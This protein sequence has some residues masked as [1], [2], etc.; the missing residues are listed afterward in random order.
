MNFRRWLD[1]ALLLTC[2]VTVLLTLQGC[3]NQYEEATRE[4]YGTTQQRLLELGKK[5]EVGQVSNALLIKTYARQLSQ[6]QPALDE[7]AQVLGRD[8]TTEGPQYQGL[9]ERLKKID[10][11]PDNKGQFVPVFQELEALHAATDP[12]VYNDALLDVV[13]TLADLSGGTLARINIPK[14]AQTA[15]IEGGGTVPGSYLVGNPNYGHWNQDS[16]GNS[17]WSWYGKYALFSSVIRGFGGFGSNYHSGPIYHD[18]WYKRDRYGYYHD[19]GR[20][21]YGTG[22]DRHSWDRGQ[23]R[24]EKKGIK[25]PKPKNYGSVSGQ[26]RVSTYA[27]MRQKSAS[28]LRS[29]SIPSTSGKTAK[30]SSSF[31]GSSTRGTS[32]GSRSGFGGK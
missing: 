8:A 18:S 10:Q 14:D 30:R 15:D 3:S 5:I 29:G 9:L 4:A 22:T 24:L 1:H 26:K 19:Y 17:F 11:Q 20:K 21:T 25:T 13:N 28:T 16:S 23:K 2:L 32:S 12:L 31:F 7:V 6:A 27:S